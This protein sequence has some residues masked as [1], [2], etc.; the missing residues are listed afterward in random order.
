MWLKKKLR[1]LI[2]KWSVLSDEWVIPRHVWIDI[3]EKRY[4][5]SLEKIA[6][7]EEIWPGDPEITRA[8]SLVICMMGAVE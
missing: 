2:I 1:S 6:E 8:R 3:D 5:E 4:G 7:A